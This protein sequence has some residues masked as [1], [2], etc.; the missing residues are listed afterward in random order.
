MTMHPVIE[1]YE[2]LSSLTGKMRE[3]ATQGEWDRLVELEQKCSRHVESMKVLDTTASL[4]E[5][6]RLRKVELIRKIL[7][8]D[9][10]VR[11]CTE[12][13]MAQLQRIMQSARQ[14][15][16]LLEAYSSGA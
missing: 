8:D 11:N 5:R 4:D 14:E 10:E 13:W 15:N 9:A 3:A 12:P 1:N 7:A 2:Q 6:T 16:R